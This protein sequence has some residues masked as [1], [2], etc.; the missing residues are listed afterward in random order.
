LQIM[1]VHQR[2]AETFFEQVFEEAA[3]EIASKKA[4]EAAQVAAEEE[5]RLAS[6]DIPPEQVINDLVFGVL[7]PTVTKKAERS[8]FNV[9]FQTP[10]G[11]VLY[12]R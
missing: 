11:V 2:T 12:T 1:A 10:I 7:F 5:R 9:Q 8:S 3:I 4:E 6:L